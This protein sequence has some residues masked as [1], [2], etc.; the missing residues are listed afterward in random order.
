MDEMI[1]TDISR[2]KGTAALWF[3]AFIGFAG[4]V[5]SLGIIWAARD[6]LSIDAYIILAGIAIVSLLAMMT[7]AVVARA[8]R[9]GRRRQT[10]QETVYSSAFY[11]N[12][13]PSLV[14]NDGTPV[15]ANRA[16]SQL[17]KSLNAESVGDTPPV[18]DRLFTLSLIHI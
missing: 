18:V 16:Y 3:G 11:N 13:V 6:S 10:D 15:R 9:R 12:L 5:S 4:L 14:L 2:P 1:R 17:A 8:R 7:F